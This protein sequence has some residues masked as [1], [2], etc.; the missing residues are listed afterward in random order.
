MHKD[1]VWLWPQLWALPAFCTPLHQCGHVCRPCIGHSAP[2]KRRRGPQL[3]SFPWSATRDDLL[4]NRQSDY[5]NV[6]APIC[7]HTRAPVETEESWSHPGMANRLVAVPSTVKI[8]KNTL[9]IPCQGGSNPSGNN[10]SSP[11]SRTAKLLITLFMAVF[12]LRSP[13]TTFGSLITVFGTESHLRL[14]SAESALLSSIYWGA[15]IS[16]RIATIA[17]STR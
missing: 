11:C 3:G 6:P 8:E 7:V 1:L 15:F 14:S 2:A 5:C 17:I 12:F 16:V 4:L 10:R 13:F 9:W